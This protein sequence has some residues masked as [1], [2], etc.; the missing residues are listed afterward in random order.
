MSQPS[1]FGY[2]TAWIAVETT[3]TVQQSLAAELRLRD[4]RSCDW[5]EGVKESYD[6]ADRA[7]FITPTISGWTLAVGILLLDA[8]DE[9]L[10][11]IVRLSERHGSAQYFGN[12]RVVD[13]YAWAKA[14]CGRLVRAYAF[15][16]E[17]DETPW[18]TGGLT[19]EEKELGLIFDDPEDEPAPSAG[20]SSEDF[21]KLMSSYAERK[22]PREKDVMAI[23]GK[24]SIAPTQIEEYEVSQIPGQF[25][26]LEP[27][28]KR[29]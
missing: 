21:L 10:N 9:V 6:T 16:G 14:E 11:L 24:W 2:K 8:S 4:L 18:N 26:Y 1:P 15:L 28:D 20:A 27:A 29:R 5:E 3:A 12:Y 25:G 22:Y 7:V 17:R 23:A 19:A 13:Y